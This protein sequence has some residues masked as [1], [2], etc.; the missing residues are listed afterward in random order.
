MTEAKGLL[1]GHKSNE[2]AEAIAGYHCVYYTFVS[3]VQRRLAELL[4]DCPLR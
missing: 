4:V 3:D 2:S 1:D